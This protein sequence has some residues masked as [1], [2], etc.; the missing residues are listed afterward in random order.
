MSPKSVII[1][2][3]SSE[4][5]T[6][7]EQQVIFSARISLAQVQNENPQA[8]QFKAEQL[9]SKLEGGV[10]E[11]LKSPKRM[12]RALRQ[13]QL[14]DAGISDRRLTIAYLRQNTLNPLHVQAFNHLK[15]NRFSEFVFYFD[16]EAGAS[17]PLTAIIRA[18]QAIQDDDS[19]ISQ[20]LTRSEVHFKPSFTQSIQIYMK[21]Q[22]GAKKMAQYI[23]DNNDEP[24][25]SL[26]E[27]AVKYVRGEGAQLEYSGLTFLDPSI[28]S[29]GA[30][31]IGRLYPLVY[32]AVAAAR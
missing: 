29:A 2:T 1:S 9:A 17:L 13:L 31:M 6:P 21:M 8:A 20:A 14:K 27:D 30:G 5:L 19:L 22:E 26:V 4:E 15:A 16:F 28:S 24:G 10:E 12:S 32:P 25:Y 7:A 11:L 18:D 3:M 23:K